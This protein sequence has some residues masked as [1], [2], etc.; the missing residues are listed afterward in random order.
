MVTSPLSL[1]YRSLRKEAW[2]L[3]LFAILW[4][5]HKSESL[6]LQ[7]FLSRNEKESTMVSVTMSTFPPSLEI[8]R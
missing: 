4:L 1:I 3:F 2:L 5:L 8:R 7:M 6:S